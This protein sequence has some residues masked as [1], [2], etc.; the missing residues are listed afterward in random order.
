MSFFG[1]GELPGA[2]GKRKQRRNQSDG[3]HEAL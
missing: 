1:F 3:G 2:C